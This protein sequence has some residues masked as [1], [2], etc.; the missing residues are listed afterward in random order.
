MTERSDFS[1]YENGKYLGFVFREVRANLSPSQGGAY[2]GHFIILEETLRDLKLSARPVDDIIQ[3]S[4]E[5]GENGSMKIAEDRGFPSLRGFPSFPADP[6][7]EGTSW[8]AHATRAFDPDNSGITTKVPI[9][10]SY[11]FKG[12]EK[13]K[14]YDVWRVSAKYASRYTNPRPPSG[15]FSGLQGTHDVEILIE[16]STGLPLLMRDRFDETFTF[17]D[18]RTLGTRAFALPSV[19]FPFRSIRAVLLLASVALGKEIHHLQTRRMGNLQTE[20]TLMESLQRERP[21][22]LARTG[23]SFRIW[24]SN[25]GK[26]LPAY[27][28]NQTRHT[29]ES[30][31][32]KEKRG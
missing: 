15:G 28:M 25:S 5:I 9:V 19:N 26:A 11:T 8:I 14:G 29:G 27:P 17:P 4:L 32:Q 2:R 16:A 22:Q 1:R 7:R 21:H 12:A 10:A 18:G 3:V 13:Y 23:L 30:R 20:R 31:S 6:V 24:L